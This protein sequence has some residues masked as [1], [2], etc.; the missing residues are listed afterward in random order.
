MPMLFD[1]SFGLPG[2]SEVLENLENQFWWGRF[3]QQIWRDTV[4]A[5]AT[6]DTGNSTTDVLRSGLL[7]G[8]NS[9]TQQAGI[10]TPG[11]TNGL[12]NIWGILLYAQKMTY[13]G[14]NQDRFT[15]Y[16]MTGGNVKSSKILIPGEA[17]LG[18]S[19][20]ASEY[21]VREQLAQAGF[22]FDD[23]NTSGGSVVA[24]RDI[25]AVTADK[26]LTAADADTL[27]TNRGAAGAVNFTLPAT[28]AKLLRFGIFVAA[29]QNVTLTSGTADTL[30]TFAD[31]TADTVALVT[32]SK[33][34][35][36][37]FEVLGD[38]T[39]WIVIPHLWIAGTT[40]PT[41]LTENAGAIGGSSDGNLPALVDPAG[42]AGASVIAGIREVATQCNSIL[43][44]LQ[45][46]TKTT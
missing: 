9:T 28:P 34:I 40:L 19:G 13:R 33:L 43:A 12:Q 26:T 15:G 44:L 3:E 30:I 1:G 24:W 36:G 42:D 35:G 32:A 17:D 21:V 8:L 31:A 4:I 25:V 18:I 10:W 16:V 46:A 37:M 6:R 5:G 22:N 7:L 29:A 38:G 41:A 20:H 27:F 2:F 39:G 23:F 11:A 14:A 45:T